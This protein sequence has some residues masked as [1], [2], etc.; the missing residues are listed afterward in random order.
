MIL[1]LCRAVGERA[2][3]AVIGGGA[4]TLEEAGRACGTGTDC[5]GCHYP[6]RQITTEHE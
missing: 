4:R 1:C 3:R 2:V 5:G 6:A